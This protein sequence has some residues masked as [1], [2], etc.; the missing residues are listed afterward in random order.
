MNKLDKLLNRKDLP[1]K[2]IKALEN[3]KKVLL[4]DKEV[5]K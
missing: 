5:K 1:K 3:K 2:V 4:N